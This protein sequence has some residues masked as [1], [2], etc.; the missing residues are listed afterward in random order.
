MSNIWGIHIRISPADALEVIEG[1]NVQ[2]GSTYMEGIATQQF[3]AWY[4]DYSQQPVG[5]MKRSPL[6]I[7][8]T[9]KCFFVACQ[10]GSTARQKGQTSREHQHE[11]WTNEPVEVFSFKFHSLLLFL[12]VFM[13]CLLSMF[14]IKIGNAKCWF[15]FL[16][17]RHMCTKSGTEGIIFG[18]Q[19]LS[20]LSAQI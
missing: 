17:C 7:L 3:N 1:Y 16:R 2:S 10:Y 5:R 12:P 19:L 9:L 20:I 11:R 13:G 14:F 6:A 18:L 15:Q 4:C 8:M